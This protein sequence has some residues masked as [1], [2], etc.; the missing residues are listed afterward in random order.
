MWGDFLE[1]FLIFCLIFCLIL[2]VIFAIKFPILYIGTGVLALIFF[3]YSTLKYLFIFCKIY[4]K[5]YYIKVIF[6]PNSSN[7]LLDLFSFIACGFNVAIPTQNKFSLTSLA[8]FLLTFCTLINVSFVLTNNE[9][10]FIANNFFKISDIESIKIEDRKHLCDPQYVT[11][12]LTN[13]T[14]IELKLSDKNFDKLKS[15][16]VLY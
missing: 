1:F 4:K 15:I 11:V 8:V 6:A 3:I 13:D 5:N 12:T 7:F 2:F 9:E 10:V 14:V 16:G